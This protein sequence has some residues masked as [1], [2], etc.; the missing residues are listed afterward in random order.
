MEWAP[1]IGVIIRLR[2]G[3][4]T[5]VFQQHR[6]WQQ[7]PMNPSYICAPHGSSPS[8][9]LLLKNKCEHL[10][11]QPNLRQCYEY[12]NWISIWF[13][14]GLTPQFRKSKNRLFWAGER[15]RE[16]IVWKILATSPYSAQSVKIWA[17]HHLRFRQSKNR[18]FWGGERLRDYILRKITHPL[19]IV[20]DL[21][22]FE[23][24]ISYG[25]EK[26]KIAYFWVVRGCVTIFCEKSCILSILCTICENL[27]FLSF[28]VLERVK[29][30]ILGCWE[31]AWL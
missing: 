12:V 19:P 9:D 31:V 6:L 30:L 3:L 7:L 29:S 26:E 22:K 16:Y 21:W 17:F 25:L 5:F 23:L 13:L 28:T 4:H 15:L 2:I 24:S 1:S 20:H 10:I 27:S 14:T 18:L 8:T 11:T